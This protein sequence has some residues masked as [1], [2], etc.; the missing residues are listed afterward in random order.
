M[1]TPQPKHRLSEE[2]KLWG[3]LA[4]YPDADALKAAAEKVRD[5]GYRQMG[6]LHALPG[7][8]ARP[9]HGRPADDPA[10]A[11]VRGAGLSAG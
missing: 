9:G 2:P 5:A 3:L 10:V 1:E 8:R 4:E 11:G 6:L 7:P